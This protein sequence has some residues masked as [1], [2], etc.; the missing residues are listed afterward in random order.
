MAARIATSNCP[1]G[2]KTA[3]RE[4][5][6]A[7]KP[8]A[9]IVFVCPAAGFT[10]CALLPGWGYQFVDVLPTRFFPVSSRE[11]DMTAY[12]RFEIPIGVDQKSAP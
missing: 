5:I 6:S 8:S 10:D 9:L 3:S 2:T 12:P 4:S 1:D 7:I 11:F